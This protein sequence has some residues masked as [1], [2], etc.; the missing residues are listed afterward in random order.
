MAPRS[1]PTKEAFGQSLLGAGGRVSV[2]C[3]VTSF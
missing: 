1:E 2:S 3:V